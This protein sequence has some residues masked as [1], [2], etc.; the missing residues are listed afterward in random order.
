M[1]FGLV[2]FYVNSTLAGPLYT[3]ILNIYN[4]FWL[5]FMAHQPL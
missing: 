5:G 3:N 4:L 2:G 1:W